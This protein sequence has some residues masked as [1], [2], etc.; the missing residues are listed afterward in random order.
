MT[1]RGPKKSSLEGM[2]I[3]HCTLYNQ[4]H[5]HSRQCTAILSTLINPEYQEIQPYW[6]IGIGSVKINPSL[7]MMAKSIKSAEKTSV[8]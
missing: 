1:S 5:P 8:S 6:T 4:I 7:L 2:Y 3:V